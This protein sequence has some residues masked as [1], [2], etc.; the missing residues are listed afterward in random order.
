MVELSAPT[1][2]TC[3]APQAQAAC[4]APD[5]RAH[6]CTPDATTCGCTAN[7]PTAAEGGIRGVVQEKY[8]AAARGVSRDPTERRAVA[9]HPGNA[10]NGRPSRARHVP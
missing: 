6:C 3:C 10:A 5:A 1:A 7:S 9:A 8:A 4:C 2:S